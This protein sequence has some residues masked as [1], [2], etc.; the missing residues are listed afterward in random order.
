MGYSQESLEKAGKAVVNDL[1][2]RQAASQFNVPISTICDR[3]SGKIALKTT[4]DRPPALAVHV[5]TKNVNNIKIAAK[6]G[7]GLSRR[8]ILRR[9][10]V[11]CTRTQL[12][13]S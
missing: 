8:Q 12:K 10:H 6:L 5:E 7:V 4:H 9:T 1:S 13:T 11:L 3:V 2:V